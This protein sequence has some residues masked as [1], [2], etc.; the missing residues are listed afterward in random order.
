MI[1]EDEAAVIGAV[2]DGQIDPL[3]GSAV[4]IPDGTCL[5]PGQML[6][7]HADRHGLVGQ[8]HG[9]ILRVVR[10]AVELFQHLVDCHRVVVAVEI[11][12]VLDV[13]EFIQGIQEFRVRADDGAKREGQDPAASAGPLRLGGAAGDEVAESD[14]IL[15]AHGL[16]EIGPH[17]EEDQVGHGDAL[18]HAEIH[19]FLGGFGLQMEVRHTHG[20]VFCL[21]I[22]RAKGLV[23]V[24]SAALLQNAGALDVGIDGLTVFRQVIA[25]EFLVFGPALFI[26][27]L[28]QVT[29]QNFF[30]GGEGLGILG[31]EAVMAV[32]LHNVVDHDDQTGGIHQTVIDV[33]IHTVVAFRHLHHGDLHHGDFGLVE[34]LIGLFL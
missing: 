10:S 11:D 24:C 31:P 13:L 4:G 8:G 7:L 25:P 16:G 29:D 15:T 21:H 33:D 12:L 26:L 17:G 27:H 6:V 28:F 1:I 20:A 22:C 34:L 18:H 23:P 32:K 3:G 2:G 30:E 9:D 19:Q 5:D 14:V